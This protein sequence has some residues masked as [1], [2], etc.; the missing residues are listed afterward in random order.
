MDVMARTSSPAPAG[1]ASRL[2]A[3][4]DAGPTAYQLY[5]FGVSCALFSAAA[6]A[7]AVSYLLCPSEVSRLGG[8]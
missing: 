5:A 1:E 4:S 3:G 6:A 2:P 8:N 7:L